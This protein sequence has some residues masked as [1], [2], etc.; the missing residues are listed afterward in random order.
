MSE[1]DGAAAQIRITGGNP[2]PEQ[3]A[4]VTAVLSAALEQL[5]GEDRPVNTGLD[6]WQRSQRGLRRPL[7][8]GEWKQFPRR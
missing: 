4:A 8:R 6:S 1:H 5:A 7:T 3:V 2:S